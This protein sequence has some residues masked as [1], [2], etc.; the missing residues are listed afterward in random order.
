[1]RVTDLLCFSETFFTEEEGSGSGPGSGSDEASITA[2]KQSRAYVQDSIKNHG[3]WRSGHFWEETFWI[4]VREEVLRNVVRPT[5]PPDK[6]SARRR[7]LSQANLRNIVYGQMGATGFNMLSVGMPRSQVESCLRRMALGNGIAAEE[8]A[9]LLGN[10]F[11][12][13]S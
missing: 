11:S 12:S 6:G 2:R 5:S 1:M 8:T 4:A 13:R 10:L 9:A 7:S 3:I